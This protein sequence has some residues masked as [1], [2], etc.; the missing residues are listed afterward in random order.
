M[1]KSSKRGFLNLTPTQNQTLATWVFACLLLIF[2][3]CVFI[4]APE[5]LPV[6]K[7]R[8]LAIS[9]A[10]LAGLFAFFFTGKVGLKITSIQT[11]FGDFGVRAS[12]GVAVF[13]F[14]LLW[15]LSP[16]AP[17][18]VEEIKELQKNVRKL[19]EEFLHANSDI[20]LLKEIIGRGEKPTVSPQAKRIATQIA[21]DADPFSLALKAIAENRWDDARKLLEQAEQDASAADSFNIYRA[22]GQI[23]LFAG[24]YANA[25]AWFQRARSLK[26]NNADILNETGVALI[27][28]GKY[29][30]A[31]PLLA[32][33]AEIVANALGKDH[34]DAGRGLNNL[35][36][37][38]HHLG[39][40][41]KAEELY[42]RALSILEKLTD[43]DNPDL[44]TCLNN[45]ASIYQDQHKLAEAESTYKRV[46]KLQATLGSNE[47]RLAVTYNNLAGVYAEMNRVEEA[48]LLYQRARD[49]QEKVLGKE[50]L[51]LA[52]TLNNLAGL[53][54]QQGQ[55]AESERLY[56]RALAI[57]EKKLG[58]ADPVV[59]ESLN[60]IAEL[61]MRRA[62]FDAA[63][64]L[65]RQA[66][67]IC[68]QRQ[69]TNDWT[70]AVYFKNL[71]TVYRELGRFQEAEQNYWTALAIRTNLFGQAHPSVA[72]SYHDL[73]VLCSRQGRTEN[74]IQYLRQA[75]SVLEHLPERD[76]AAVL[77]NRKELA[78]LES[79]RTNGAEASK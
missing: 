5:K 53:Y 47:A 57:R 15:W 37:V 23:E 7:Q 16:W 40:L 41:A 56:R 44:A 51:D 29:E 75:V 61:Q 43:A 38:Y 48:E 52:T 19:Q 60:N 78:Y 33:G 6:F 76:D 34:A 9:S 42:L 46:V 36:A 54:L 30:E 59:A 79:T 55:P 49:L 68:A 28:E 35:A 22:R 70:V 12:G 24:Q 39:R 72:T 62:L 31:L 32:Q 26:P 10:L 65:L 27:Y 77:R 8:M 17:V 64:P 21:S 66:L 4:F 14:V 63:E 67:G 20:A 73:A 13:V 71:G 18:E 45:L 11:R 1:T 25:V 58:P 2:F 69:R 50:H 3:V 74:A